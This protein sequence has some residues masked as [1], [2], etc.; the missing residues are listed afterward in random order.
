MLRTPT[1][2]LVAT[3]VTSLA[4]VL[5]APT[6]DAATTSTYRHGTWAQSHTTTKAAC[7][8]M[9]TRAL[10]SIAYYKGKNVQAGACHRID[11]GTGTSRQA[12]WLYD[13]RYD[14]SLPIWR[15]DS[16]LGAAPAA[17]LAGAHSFKVNGYYATKAEAT[18]VEAARITQLKSASFGAKV[19][20]RSGIKQNA[21]T[22]KWE[23]EIDYDSRVP[24]YWGHVEIS[25]RA[26]VTTPSIGV[27]SPI[28]SN[29]TPDA[30]GGTS[31]K[32]I[33]PPPSDITPTVP[34]KVGVSGIDISGHTAISDWAGWKD[35]GVNFLYTKATEGDYYKNPKFA[36]QYIG[37]YNNGILRGAYHFANPSQS[38]GAQQAD[39]FLSNGGGWSADGKTLP[40]ALDVEWN[41]YGDACF[42]LT[43]DQ[44][45]QWITSFVTEYKSRTGVVPVIYTAPLWWNKC[46]GASYAPDANGVPLWTARPDTPTPGELPAGW[47]K[48]M[49]WQNAWYDSKGYDTNIFNGTMTQLKAYASTGRF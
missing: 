47:A 35:A 5:V 28:P 11:A 26:G 13:V 7:E 42:G 1:V 39:Y 20:W 31:T 27:N 37:S 10:Q 43:Q 24:S 17:K 9:R 19:T 46:V 49:I 36:E 6:A 21:I 16:R 22:K 4:P 15:S 3:A 32:V 41:P 40:G 30:K 38:T 25:Q 18:K 34:E 12:G 33:T 48:H 8:T 23:Y 44:M 45:G 2:A 14:R 29:V